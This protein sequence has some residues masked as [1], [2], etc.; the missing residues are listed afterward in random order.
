L[1][2]IHTHPERT[3]PGGFAVGDDW[4]T[5]SA[6]AA[7]VEYLLPQ[8]LD[9]GSVDALLTKRLELECERVRTGRRTFYDTFDGRLHAKGLVLVHEEMRLVLRDDERERAGLAYPEKAPP[10]VAVRELPDGPLRAAL[11]PICGVR[12]LQATASL[13]GRRRLLRVLDGERKTIVRL[14]AEEATLARNGSGNGAHALRP[15]LHV[16]PVRGYAKALRGVRGAL[17]DD[18][19]LIP[20]T[21]PLRDEAVWRA[22][23]APG[24]VSSKVV[25]AFAPDLRADRAAAALAGRL[26]AVIEA[27]L[28]G[29]LAEIDTEFLHDLRVAVRRTRSLQR[30]LKRVFP[31][32]PLAH[33]RTEFRWLQRVTGPTRDLDVYLADLDGAPDLDPLRAVLVERRTRERAAME[34]ALRSPRTRRMLEQWSVF[35]E[36]LADAPPAG[37]DDA[38]RPIFAVTAQRIARVYKTLARMGGAI[39]AASAPLALHDLRKKGKELRYLLEFFAPLFPSSVIDPMV[40]SLK[41]LQDTLGRFQDREVQAAL[42][43]ELS[44]EVATREGG[45]AA[46]M[47]MGVLAQRLDADR[48][49]ARS[50]FAGRFGAFAAPRQRALVRE[51]FG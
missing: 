39:D 22:G 10:R 35:V 41:A 29:A 40:A 15:R 44:N 13:R 23:G 18:L 33:F 4:F 25:V 20:A 34:R 16:V 47:A 6:M 46:L 42:L 37:R 3:R 7:G 31:P 27:N 32:A 50:E 21:E 36:H 17:E 5:S 38:L 19:G 24:G 51:T 1:K 12:A 26:V 11:A 49:Q 48:A 45:G 30:E 43:R 2:L 14:V 9:V 28:P 8:G